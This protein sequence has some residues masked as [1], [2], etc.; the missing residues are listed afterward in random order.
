MAKT[1]APKQEVVRKAT[2]SFFMNE[3]VFVLDP[4]GRTDAAISLDWES[5]AEVC[6][7]LHPGATFLVRELP[8]RDGWL[9]IVKQSRE[10]VHSHGG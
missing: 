8:P 7:E 6:P 5:A 10:D 9:E 4:F 1:K 2:I 3:K